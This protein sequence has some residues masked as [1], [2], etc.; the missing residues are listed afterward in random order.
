MDQSG[1]VIRTPGPGDL[2]WIISEH[3]HHYVQL[4]GFDP[5]FERVVAEVLVNFLT[6][7]DPEREALWVVTLDGQRVGSLLC[8]DE[9]EDARFR[10]FYVNPSCRGRGVGTRLLDYGIRAAKDMGY[11]RIALSTHAEQ[12]G[13]CRLYAAAGFTIEDSNRSTA[14]GRVLNEQTWVLP[15]TE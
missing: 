4:E 14:Y 11:E 3:G 5:D 13:A 15:L 7:R 12:E 2:G 8:A 6:V 10:L 9:G 1:I